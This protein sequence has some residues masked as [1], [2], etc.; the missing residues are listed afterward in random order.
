ML[1]ADRA[2]SATGLAMRSFSDMLR[3]LAYAEGASLAVEWRYAE[4]RPERLHGLAEELVRANVELIITMASDDATEAAI[5]ATRTIPIV[6]HNATF[7]L[8]RGLINSLARP[9]GNVTG[10]TYAP[11]ETSLKQIQIFK[12][13][14]PRSE[15]AAFLAATPRHAAEK[16][17]VSKAMDYARSLWRN[18]EIFFVTQPEDIPDTLKRIAD[19]RPDALWVAT[20]PVIRSRLTEIAAFARERRLPSFGSGILYVQAGGMM[21]YGPDFLAMW[22]LSAT[23]VGRI[24]KGAKPA[25][26]PV[27]Q[28][29]RYE[30]V[31]N[32]GTATVIGH[33]I[34]KGVLLR[35][36]RVIE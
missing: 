11:A 15:R 32:G 7:P 36:D 13:T 30:L 24:F 22:Q 10:T 35:A 5:Q 20:P 4:G 12:E 23:Y 1:L 29:R 26:L 18:T 8:E 9:G 16:E 2:D 3:P 33:N 34:P 6:M 14:V 27:E 17:V 25:D 21:Y 19:W 28:P 31:I